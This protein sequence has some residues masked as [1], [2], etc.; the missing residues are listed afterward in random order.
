MEHREVPKAVFDRADLT[1]ITGRDAGFSGPERRWGRLASGLWLEHRRSGP[2]VV[3][4]RAELMVYGNE[5]AADANSQDGWLYWLLCTSTSP[6]VPRGA[7]RPTPGI[8]YG[9]ISVRLDHLA[10]DQLRQALTVIDEVNE[11]VLNVAREYSVAELIGPVRGQPP[12]LPDLQPRDH[13]DS[14]DGSS[15]LFPRAA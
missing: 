5:G 1:G 8:D 6:V 11:L 9:H 3:P 10:V 2:A 7:V 13:R 14:V 4:A 15:P 12:R